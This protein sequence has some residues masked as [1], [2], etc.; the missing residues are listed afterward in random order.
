MLPTPVLLPAE[1]HGWRRL[2][3]YSPWGCK[4]SDITKQ[5]TH[6]HSVYVFPFDS[7]WLCYSMNLSKFSLNAICILSFPE[8]LAYFLLLEI[9]CV[10]V[11]SCIQLF[12]IRGIIAHQA[13]L[14]MG[15]PR[16]EYWSGLPF[17][18]PEIFL[19]QGLNPHLL[20]L[21]HCRQI[22][23]LLSHWGSLW[24]FI[25]YLIELQRKI[26]FVNHF[27][28]YWAIFIYFVSLKLRFI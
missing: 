7:V 28:S 2:V 1:F 24:N 10:C 19:P 12:V 5:L 9:L 22:L 16:Q 13:S 23:Y 27:Q 15:F 18:S 6:T 17:P 20:C 8:V 26:F 25:A 11:L 3:G 4:E 14:S 21:L